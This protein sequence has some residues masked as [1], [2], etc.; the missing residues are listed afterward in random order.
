[1]TILTVGQELPI[2]KEILAVEYVCLRQEQVVNAQQIELSSHRDAWYIFNDKIN[3]RKN[4]N[5]ARLY[6]ARH[7]V[8]APDVVYSF[9][10]ITPPKPLT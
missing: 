1:M 10:G 3:E 6:R 8:M 9:G 7:P 4:E 5:M 2:D